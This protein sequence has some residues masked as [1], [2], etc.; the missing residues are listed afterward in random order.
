M[1]MRLLL[2][3][4]V[5]IQ[6]AVDRSSLDAAIV[7]QSGSDAYD[8][9]LTGIR[10]SLAKSPY[11]IQ[12]VNLAETGAPKRL[13]AMLA[14][15]P[16]LVTAV[17]LGAWD[18]LGTVAIPVL[19]AVVLREDVRSAKDRRAVAVIYADVPLAAIAFNLRAMFPGRSRIALIHRSSRPPLDAVAIARVKQLGFELM[20][21]ECAGPDKLLAAFG[22]AKGAADFV[23][24]EPDPELYNSATVKPLVLAS[25]DS[26]LP[27][28]GFSAAF[29]R[30]G[31][32]AGVY[33]DFRDLGQQTGERIQRILEGNPADKKKAPEDEVRKVVIAVN[34]RIAR[35]MG[36]EP[37]DRAH[38]VIFK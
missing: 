10:A 32:L 11:K 5:S 24:T 19:P 2:L 8:E 3:F 14:S 9:A 16:R 7:F 29:V 26:R 12:Y 37:A 6:G 1:L 4:A 27:I 30:A 20:V 36:I 34:E 17:G 31:A 33:P 18:Q 15:A 38:A 35:L 21:V 25:L 22:S 13:E 28:V 23:V